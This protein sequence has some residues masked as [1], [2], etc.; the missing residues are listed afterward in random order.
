[1]GH[2][3]AHITAGPVLQPEHLIPYLIPPSGLLPYLSRMQ[4]RQGNLLCAYGVHLLAEDSV[5]SFYNPDPEGQIDVEACCKLSDIPGSQH[6]D[7]TSCL[8]IRRNFPQ[9]WYEHL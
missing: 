2:A 8:H 5:Y 1:M 6:K 7:M 9:S 4:R 3:E